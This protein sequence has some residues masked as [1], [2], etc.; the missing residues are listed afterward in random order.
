MR[1][2]TGANFVI[3]CLVTDCTDSDIIGGNGSGG[4]GRH[5]IGGKYCAIWGLRRAF[6]TLIPM[7]LRRTIENLILACF[8]DKD[9]RQGEWFK[10]DL[11]NGEQ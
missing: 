3:Q 11:Y 10:S 1:L 6:Y 5:G 9:S 8:L 2:K 4:G 7:L